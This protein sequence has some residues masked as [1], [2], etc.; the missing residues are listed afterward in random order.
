MQVG[1]PTT[2]ATSEYLIQ[3][4]ATFDSVRT[5]LTSAIT[6]LARQHDYTDFELAA[7][8]PGK[9]ILNVPERS[10]GAEEAGHAGQDAANN[11]RA[12]SQS[13]SV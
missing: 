6:L 10:S 7:I 2:P 4:Q 5:Q 12:E 8:Y 9:V 1:I 11:V 3:L 13:D